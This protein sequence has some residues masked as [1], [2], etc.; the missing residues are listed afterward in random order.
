MRYYTDMDADIC[1]KAGL[2]VSQANAYLTLLQYGEQTPVQL[3]ERVNESRTN[4]YNLITQLQKLGLAE[5]SPEIKGSW[6]ANNPMKLKQLALSRVKAAQTASQEL[7]ALLPK[8]VSQYRI[9]H[10]QPGITHMDGAEALETIYKDILVSKENPLIIP[11]KH[12]R[13]DPETAKIIDS[14]I[15]KQQKYGIRSQV[16]LA[17]TSPL[18]G[19]E[20]E[21]EDQGVSVSCVLSEQ[22]EAQII[23]YSDNVAITTFRD[24]VSSTVINNP[25]IAQTMRILFGQLW[26]RQPQ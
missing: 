21:L 24:G 25:E 6:R 15:G 18:A 3:A 10:N 20:Q 2:N 4:T 19:H 16:I 13:D 8:L 12:D 5:T 17:T 23:I 22:T 7:S 1:T 11:S 9:S 14:Q 26:V